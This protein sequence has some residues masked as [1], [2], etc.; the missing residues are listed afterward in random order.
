MCKSCAAGTFSSTTASTSCTTCPS[1]WITKITGATQCTKLP[2]PICCQARAADPMYKE[3]CLKIQNQTSC[4][5]T[6]GLVCDWTCGE[7]DAKK[8]LEQ[9]EKWCNQHNN[10]NS[11]G[12]VNAT[13]EWVPIPAN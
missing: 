9:Y 10:F 13:C 6:Y 5:V 3:L 7:C 4:L 12:L 1:G 8:G 11:C 2:A